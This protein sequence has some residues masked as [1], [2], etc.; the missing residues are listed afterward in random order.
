MENSH[1]DY[2]R[3]RKILSNPEISYR[4]KVIL[5][6]MHNMRMVIKNKKKPIKKQKG[7]LRIIQYIYEKIKNYK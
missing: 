5:L 4:D 7:I 3:I 6:K 2:E 1:E